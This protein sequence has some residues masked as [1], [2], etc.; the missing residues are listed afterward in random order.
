MPLRHLT[1]AC[2]GGCGPLAGE[3]IPPGT[4]DEEDTFV[5]EPHCP[6]RK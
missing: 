6:K 5:C 2:L 1:T 3:G 4:E